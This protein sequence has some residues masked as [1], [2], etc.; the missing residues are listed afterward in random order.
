MTQKLYDTDSYLKE[1]T[2]NVISCEKSG[3]AFRV[4]LDKTC[5][6]PTEGGQ[7][8]DEGTLGGQRVK[9]VILEG[10]EII[11]V[12][13]KELS[14]KVLGE[15][16]FDIRFDKMQQHTAEHIVCGIV[17]RLYGYNNVGFHLGPDDVTFDFDGMLSREQLYEIEALANAA[18]TKNA[19]VKCYYPEN[20]E[21]ENYRSKSG[22]EGRLRI[23]DVNGID[24]C[25]CCAPH[26]STTGQV[27]LIH[28]TDSYPYKSG[29]RIHMSCGKRAV[30]K[31]QAYTKNLREIAKRLS[32]G[33][34]NA[35]E[36]F[37]RFLKDHE[38]TLKQL[39]ELKKEMLTL[40]ANSQAAVDGTLTVFENSLETGLLRQYANSLGGKYTDMLF[41][42]GQ[43]TDN[44]YPFVAAS[45]KRDMREVANRMRSEL[46][47]KGGGSDKMIQGSVNADKETIENFI[48]SI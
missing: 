37:E 27:G 7:Y 3:D 32:S 21:S 15:I 40:K 13:E 6:F 44:G 22:I 19:P 35:A 26:L 8:F 36:F 5:F 46:G 16:D 14:G 28:F 43:K 2:A 9:D 31:L 17:N 25:A 18:V 45:D 24:R 39:S 4:I 11:H 23:V 20:P 38:N 33:T 30:E 12:V 47:S 29:V 41:V 42:F 10:D 1:F 34:D 48:K